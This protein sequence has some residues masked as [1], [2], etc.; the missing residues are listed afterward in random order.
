MGAQADGPSPP[1]GIEVLGADQTGQQ[2]VRQPGQALGPQQWHVLVGFARLAARLTP[3]GGDRLGRYPVQLGQQGVALHQH[4]DPG[5]ALA[6]L[7]RLAPALFAAGGDQLVGPEQGPLA[8]EVLELGQLFALV[9]QAGVVFDH[10]LV[11]VPPEALVAV[12]AA[13]IAADLG[14]GALGQP[15][16]LDR[17]GGVADHRQAGGV[18]LLA[19]RFARQQ[20][21]QGPAQAHDRIVGDHQGGAAIA[22]GP[23]E[24]QAL[25]GLQGGLDQA[26]R[27]GVALGQAVVAL[28]TPLPDAV[29]GHPVGAG[30]V[31]DQVLNE[32]PLVAGLD[33]HQAAA[34]Q[35]GQLQQVQGG[36]VQLQVPPA[37]VGHHRFATAGVEL[38]VDRIEPIQA[39]LEALHLGGLA[40]HRVE[41]SAHQLQHPLVQLKGAA[42]VAVQVAV[43]QGQA[44]DALDRIDAV[45][46]PGVAVVAV[47]RVGGAGGQQACDRMLAGQHHLLDLAVDRLEN[48]PGLR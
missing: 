40:Q 17:P 35:L 47:H 2:Q 5:Q 45:P 19:G 7:A 14:P 34:G 27:A 22:V 16:I 42:A 33:H 21:P 29:I 46:H 30:H 15:G 4:A 26:D 20:A 11:A 28:V 38:G 48:L 3:L 25:E 41:Q 13:Q 24:V 12:G 43:G 37:V 32:I 9:M 6:P 23:V 8:L 39:V 18:D 1:A 44:P 10:G 31:I 36:G